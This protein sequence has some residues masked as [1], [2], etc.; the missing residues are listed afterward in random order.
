VHLSAQS[1]RHADSVSPD[2]LQ[3]SS[4][5]RAGDFGRV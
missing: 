2:W 1:K 5:R 4:K 3:N